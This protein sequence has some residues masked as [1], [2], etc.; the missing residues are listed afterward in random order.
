ML[1]VLP[2]PQVVSFRASFSYTFPIVMI[3][4]RLIYMRGKVGTDSEWVLLTTAPV[5]LARM[6]AMDLGRGSGG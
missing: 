4:I 1:A 5:V 3:A 2:S 6:G